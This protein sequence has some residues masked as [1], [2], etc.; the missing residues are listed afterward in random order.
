MAQT[1]AKRKTTGDSVSTDATAKARATLESALDTVKDKSSE[2]L[3]TLQSAGDTAL[4]EGTDLV[5]GAQSELDSAVRRNPTLALAGALGI[6]VLLGLAL[7]SR[8]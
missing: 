1:T 6:G 8:N 5:A 3:E 7:R 2:A 4:K